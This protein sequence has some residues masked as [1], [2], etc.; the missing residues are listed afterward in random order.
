MNRGKVKFKSKNAVLRRVKVTGSGK[1][2]RGRSFG[3]HLKNSKSKKR[4]RIYKR[5]VEV[6]K[7]LEKKLQKVLGMR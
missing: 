4:N 3:R 2:L 7:T 5:P 6:N 1:I